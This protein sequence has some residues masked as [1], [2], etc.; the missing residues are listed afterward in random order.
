MRY[1]DTYKLQLQACFCAEHSNGYSKGWFTS[2]K[3]SL[4]QDYFHDTLI[5]V[6]YIS[7]ERKAKKVFCSQFFGGNSLFGNIAE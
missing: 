6:N 7:Q 1:F 3:F 5:F 4:N 2:L